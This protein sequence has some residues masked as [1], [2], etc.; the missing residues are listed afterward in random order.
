MNKWKLLEA[1]HSDKHT[2]PIK[3]VDVPGVERNPINHP[4]WSAPEKPK[5]YY[6]GDIFECDKN[7]DLLNLRGRN[8]QIIKQRFQLVGESSGDS[9]DEMTVAELKA[10]AETEEIDLGNATRKD[11]IIAVIRGAVARV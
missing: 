5:T 8:G 2:K 10:M 9:L 4:D 3:L 1:I 6:P 11:K 7:L